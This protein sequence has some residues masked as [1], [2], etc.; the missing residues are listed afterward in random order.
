MRFDHQVQR[1]PDVL[2]MGNDSPS[3][4]C[5]VP[6]GSEF[7]YFAGAKFCFGG[8]ENKIMESGSKEAGGSDINIL[9]ASRP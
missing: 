4:A 6:K 8:S 3:D 5:E 1:V 2:S 9:S 7:A